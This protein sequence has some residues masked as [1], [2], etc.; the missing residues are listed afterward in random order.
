MSLHVN[1]ERGTVGCGARFLALFLCGFAVFGKKWDGFAV[2]VIFSRFRFFTFYC[3][4]LR[5]FVKFRAV[6]R[7][8][9]IYSN[10]F[11][12]LKFVVHI[13]SSLDLILN[14]LIV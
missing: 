14:P 7:F 8:S 12:V 6:L 5:F 9:S 10:G 1:K 3:S 13:R 11:A 2:F 4:G